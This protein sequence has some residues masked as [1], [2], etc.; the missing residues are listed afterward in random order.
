MTNKE[1]VDISGR[2]YACTLTE[3]CRRLKTSALLHVKILKC[4][5]SELDNLHIPTSTCSLAICFSGL[6]NSGP[7]AKTVLGMCIRTITRCAY[8]QCMPC[9]HLM[10]FEMTGD[11][12]ALLLVGMASAFVMV[13]HVQQ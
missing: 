13:G 8:W 6:E 2:R 11:T 3:E 5:H 12:C 10:T 4:L 7:S 1:C 9:T